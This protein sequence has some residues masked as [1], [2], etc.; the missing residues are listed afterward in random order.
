MTRRKDRCDAALWVEHSGQ[1]ICVLDSRTCSTMKTLF[2]P[3]PFTVCCVHAYVEEVG[4]VVWK[5]K[6][7]CSCSWRGAKTWYHLLN[8]EDRYDTS[9]TAALHDVRGGVSTCCRQHD[10]QTCG[11]REGRCSPSH[12]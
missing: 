9:L 11:G 12:C 5:I 3:F 4:E 8:V 10:V 1:I 2:V 6:K 7:C